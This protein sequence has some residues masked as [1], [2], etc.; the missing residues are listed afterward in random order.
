[1]QLEPV[2]EI[3]LLCAA[4]FLVGERNEILSVL[5]RIAGVEKNKLLDIGQAA[6]RQRHLFR[7]IQRRQ[8][9]TGENR[10]DRDHDQKFDQREV[11]AF[12]SISFRFG[13]LS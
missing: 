5:V 10:D 12:H 2:G 6:D 11:F 8:Q 3:W 4:A 13:R 9:K 7:L 1:M